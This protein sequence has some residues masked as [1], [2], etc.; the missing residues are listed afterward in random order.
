MKMANID[1]VFDYNFTYPKTSD[2]VSTYVAIDVIK[3]LII[4]L[5]YSNQLWWGLNC[6]TLLTFVLVLVVFLSMCCGGEN[7]MLKD[8]G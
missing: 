5:C 3:I 8:L 7:G 2:G 6:C 4:L 1:A